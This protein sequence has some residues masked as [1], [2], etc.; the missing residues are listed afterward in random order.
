MDS[1]VI[2]GEFCITIPYFPGVVPQ[3]IT[4][5]EYFR[6]FPQVEIGIVNVNLREKPGLV[7]FL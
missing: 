5:L 7:K 2:A 3:N 1:V 6:E 4:K